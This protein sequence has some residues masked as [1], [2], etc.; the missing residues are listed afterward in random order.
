MSLRQNSSKK[1]KTKRTPPKIYL[2]FWPIIPWFV[3][4]KYCKNYCFQKYIKWYFSQFPLWKRNI[5]QMLVHTVIM[6]TSWRI[7]LVISS[8]KVGV[9]YT[10]V[11]NAFLAVLFLGQF[12]C[13]PFNLSQHEMTKFSVW[14]S[15]KKCAAPSCDTIPS[16]C[17]GS[18]FESKI[19]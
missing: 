12:F 7:G 5:L 2:C 15:R 14:G 13:I 9:G 6:D 4:E 8:L 11:K 18:G 1:T 10:V 3:L 19:H 17:N 16:F